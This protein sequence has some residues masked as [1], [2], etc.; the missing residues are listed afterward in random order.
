M[1]LKSGPV[2]A[3]AGPGDT[4]SGTTGEQKP[5]EVER[6]PTQGERSLTQGEL[7]VTEEERCFLDGVLP[8]MISQRLMYYMGRERMMIPLR[9]W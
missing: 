4:L 1:I 2:V 3:L 7:G 9:Y 5:A 6:P 8:A